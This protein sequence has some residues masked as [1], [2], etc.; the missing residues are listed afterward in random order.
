MQNLR[1][2][3]KF[4][5]PVNARHMGTLKDVAMQLKSITSIQKITSSM[6]MVASAKFARAER[7]LKLAV[8]YGTGA[9]AFYEKSGIL[10][11]QKENKIASNHLVIA[12]T[13]DRGLCGAANSSIGR[14]LRDMLNNLPVGETVKLVLIGEKARA[15][16]ARKFSD[17]F[18]MSF[19][20]VG[21]KPPTFEDASMIAEALLNCDYKFDKASLY[22]NKFKTVVSYTTMDQPIFSLEQLQ[23]APSLALYDS[24]DDEALRSYN[25]FLLSSFLFYA[26]KEAAASEQSA[27]MT[28]MQ[29]ATKNADELIDALKLTYNRTRQAVITKELIEIISGAAAV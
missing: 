4:V 13:S 16:L 20:E 7:E 10:E 17:H 15:F 28:A 9:T 14:T 5:P 8:P 12:I 11:H 27:R 1:L 21:K 6:K 19:T 26:L 29:S 23:Q 3:C 25:E 24:V 18:L 22:Y 2:V